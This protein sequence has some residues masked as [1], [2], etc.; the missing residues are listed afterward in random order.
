MK[1]CELFNVCSTE[2]RSVVISISSIICVYL[3][4]SNK[5]GVKRMRKEVIMIWVHKTHNRERINVRSVKDFK[6]PKKDVQYGQEI[7]FHKG[8]QRTANEYAEERRI[9]KDPISKNNK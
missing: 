8:L 1:Y 6:S 9:Y 5:G 7:R 2:I 4:I 3:A